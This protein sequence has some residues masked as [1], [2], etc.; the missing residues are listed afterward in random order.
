[1][2]IA[3][4]ITR[5]IVGG[6]QENVVLCCED[7]MRQYGDEVLLITGPPLGPE[8]SL[9]EQARAGGI[10]IAPVD[11]LQRPVNPWRDLLSYVRIKRLLRD[12]RPDVVHTHSAKG[13]ILGRAAAWSLRVPVIVHTVHG[14][15]FHPYQGRGA[16]AMIRACERWAARRCHALVSVADAMTDLM[17]AA[18]VAPREKFTTIKSGMDVQP[19]LDSAQCRD[20]VRRELGYGPDEIVIGKIA[21]LFHLKGHEYVIE[22]AKDVVR[23]NR[24]ARFL[25]VGGGTLR[26][27]LTRQ[28]AAAGLTGHFQFAGLT[29][30]HRIPE[31]IAAMDIVVHASLR[32]GLARALPQALIAGKP[33]VSFDVDGAREVV[34]DGQT[35]FLVPPQDAAGLAAA[36][37][38]LIGDASLRNRLGEEGRRRFTDEFRHE[39]MTAQLRTLYQ[40]IMLDRSF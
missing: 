21:R 22:A 38:R 37:N 9:L 31:L 17:V 2:R 30:P 8:G 19:F 10:P 12:F 18:G 1:V 24:P 26:E 25:F 4:V 28:I 20:R 14:A 34:L 39:R 15:P 11:E 35:G 40:K 13:G 32:E 36:L 7:L 5:L 27:P 16:R 6:A 29:P 3:H 33:V 23:A